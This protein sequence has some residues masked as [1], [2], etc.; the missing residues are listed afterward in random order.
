[1]LKDVLKCFVD[2]S[3]KIRLAT[4]MADLVSLSW[5][6]SSVM[7]EMFHG[8]ADADNGTPEL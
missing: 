8:L 6:S 4:A 1:M 2:S 7:T 3:D 5:A